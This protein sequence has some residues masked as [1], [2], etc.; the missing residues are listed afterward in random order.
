MFHIQKVDEV[1]HETLCNLLNAVVSGHNE[2]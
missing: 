1:H 2:L